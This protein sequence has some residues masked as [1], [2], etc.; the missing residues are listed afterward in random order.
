MSQNGSL[1][2]FG[3]NEVEQM[4]KTVHQTQRRVFYV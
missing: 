3:A 4:I 2:R 1:M